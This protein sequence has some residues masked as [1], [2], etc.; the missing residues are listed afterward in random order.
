MDSG[1]ATDG[2]AR[3]DGEESEAESF[4]WPHHLE[5]V[6]GLDLE[7]IAAATGADDRAGGGGLVDPV[8]DHGLVDVDR[9]DLTQRQPGVGLLAVG[10]LEPDDVGHLAF[11]GD[12]AL[13]DA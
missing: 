7:I 9:D 5:N 13:A 2:A 1:L 4:I 3:D 10:A 11:E 6:F 12:R 8:L